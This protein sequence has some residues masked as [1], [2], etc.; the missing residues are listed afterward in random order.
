MNIQKL[1]KTL[2]IAILIGI[3]IVPIL[4]LFEIY[5][6]RGTFISM[7]I[8]SLA[9]ADPAM[10]LQTVFADVPFAYTVVASVALPVLIA[11]ILGRVWCSWACPYTTIIELL[12]KIPAIG[13]RLK[14]SKA[15]ISGGVAPRNAIIR[16]LIFVTLLAITGVLGVPILQLLSPPSV[17]SS[18]ALLAVKGFAIT[19]EL[20]LIVILLIVELFSYRFACRY[21]CPTGTCLSLLNNRKTL[22]VSYAGSCLNCKKCIQACDMGLN[23]MTEGSDR[24]CHNCGKCIAVCPDKAKPL[25][26]KI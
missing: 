21:L 12:E 25:G 4:N 6:I 18:Q 22:H 11:L 3:F 19:A 24:L 26:W 2:Q 16:Y 7:D 5:F 9:I 23:P 14:Q 17:L 10:I 15:K 1:R 13:R 8:G 20:L